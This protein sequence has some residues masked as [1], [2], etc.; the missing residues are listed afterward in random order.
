MEEKEFEATKL[1]RLR[2]NRIRKRIQ[3]LPNDERSEK[4][5]FQL[6]GIQR[7]LEARHCSLQSSLPLP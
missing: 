5:R 3:E 6:L 1:L 7:H 2:I 4:I